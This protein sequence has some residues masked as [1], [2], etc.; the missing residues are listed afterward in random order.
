MKKIQKAEGLFSEKDS[1][2]WGAYSVKKIQK[3]GGL[4]SE[5]DSES[6]GP[7]Q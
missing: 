4:F 3:A 1:E 5:K 2:S 6:L 7:I